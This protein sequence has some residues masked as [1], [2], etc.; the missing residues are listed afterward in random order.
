[1][2]TTMGIIERS[3]CFVTILRVELI[4]YTISIP[5]DMLYTSEANIDRVILLL[6]TDL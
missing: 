5:A 1:V 2:Y 3:S 6:L 4:I